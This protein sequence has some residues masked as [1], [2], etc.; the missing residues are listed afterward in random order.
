MIDGVILGVAM[1]AA[2]WCVVGL[3]IQSEGSKGITEPY[4]TKSGVRRTAKS[5][6]SDY[7]V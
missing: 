5:I 4:Q 2:F 7:I 1:V 6:R 3:L